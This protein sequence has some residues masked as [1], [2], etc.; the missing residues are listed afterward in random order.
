MLSAGDALGR[1]NDPVPP[2]VPATAPDSVATA[3]EKIQDLRRHFFTVIEHLRETREQQVELIGNTNA[4]LDD[5]AAEPANS[6]RNALGATQ[7]E[8]AERS[9][10][11]AEGLRQMAAQAQATASAGQGAPGAPGG[12][13][14]GGGAPANPG[15]EDE[16]RFVKAAGLVDDASQ[17]MKAAQSAL[18]T[19]PVSRPAVATGQEQA[20]ALLTEALA[21]LQDQ[22]QDSSNDE[23]QE[24]GG[25]NQQGQ[26]PDEG[27]DN[28]A[29]QA[30]SGLL[31]G[32]RDRE[33]E[34]RE[35][36][37]ARASGNAPVA[38]DW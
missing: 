2:E 14:H 26:Q 28:S 37:R 29:P 5:A 9:T 20:Q 23:Q 16:A 8:L 6:T 35:R 27:E 15:A 12:S 33:A 32:V 25:D 13:T 18:M 34:R 7:L 19:E 4:H 3:V 10:G 22:N 38:K 17:E 36:N 24:Q 11:V 21:L 30:G 1:E 31:Q